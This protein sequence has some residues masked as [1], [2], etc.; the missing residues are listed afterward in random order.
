VID[1][2]PAVTD[3]IGAV[4]R[5]ADLVIVPARP[6]PDDLDAVG[7]TIDL[8]EA[9]GKPMLFLVNQATR[10]ARLTGQ[11]AIVL[12]QHGTVAPSIVHHSVAFPS[13]AAGG[14][15]VQEVDPESPQA[16]EIADLWGYVSARLSK[17]ASK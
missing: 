16:Q 14:L 11:A 2:L 7:P 8:I 15:T 6:S 3:T 10:K 4:V 12:S 1:T 13:S 5:L 17:Q 9:A